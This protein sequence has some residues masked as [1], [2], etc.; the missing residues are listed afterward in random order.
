MKWILVDGT[1]LAHRVRHSIVGGSMIEEEP[2][3]VIFG[4]LDELRSLCVDPRIR[5]ANIHL[6]F[7]SGKNFR[8]DLYPEYKSYRTP[9]GEDQARWMG[10]LWQQISLL[11]RTILPAIGVPVYG[12]E[13]FEGDDLIASAA[14]G[15]GPSEYGVMITAD[16]DL[17]QCIT[18]MVDWYNPMAR[19]YFT[20]A[21]FRDEKLVSPK[22]WARVK[23]IAGCLG[24]G[25]PGIKGVGEK[26]AITYLRGLESIR[27][28]LLEKIESK[29]GRETIAL[30][31][32]LVELP[33][34]GTPSIRLCVPS[35]WNIEALV[36][37]C[38][39]LDITDLVDG[40]RNRD[41]RD[42]QSGFASLEDRQKAHQLRGRGLDV[43]G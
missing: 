5:C 20:D 24:D 21:S 3:L 4:F 9:L 8:R 6:F 31:Q 29:E 36:G 28:R 37:I 19:R 17:W 41:W 10:I 23:A 25:V 22:N 35:K 12:H 7:D 39:E 11:K 27:P 1:W 34:E 16:G 42:I 18:P 38:Q 13:G 43:F 2:Q 15:L 14:A 33:F 40:K 32:R 30:C 26:T